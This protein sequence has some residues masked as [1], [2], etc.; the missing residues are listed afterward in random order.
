MTDIEDRQ[1]A[2]ESLLDRTGSSNNPSYQILT[3]ANVLTLIRLVGTLVFLWVFCG[4]GSRMLGTVIYV[5]TAS[6][7]FLDGMIARA[8][9]TV[10]WFGK[11]LDPIVDRLLLFS[12]VLGLLIRGELPIWVAVLVF[13]RDLYLAIGMRIVHRFHE[14]P[15]D[16]VFIGK[17]TTALLMSGFSDLLLGLPVIDGL[18]LVSVSWLPGLN[19]VA[20]PLGMLLVYAGCICSVITAAIYTY[21]GAVFIR[22][23]RRGALGA[24]R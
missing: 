10:S 16:V 20:A 7:D 9:N 1:D 12:G 17:L 14:R 19:D 5:L 18:R 24:E 6:T 4:E 15:I 8:T 3:A 13:A 2:A 23:T 21:Q 11:V 22:E